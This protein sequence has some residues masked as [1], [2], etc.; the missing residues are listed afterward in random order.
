MACIVPANGRSTQPVQVNRY[1]EP[2]S[3]SMIPWGAQQSR[4]PRSRFPMTFGSSWSPPASGGPALRSRT[5]RWRS[6]AGGACAA[7]SDTAVFG[8]ASCEHPVAG[9]R[10][11]RSRWRAQLGTAPRR[12]RPVAACGTPAPVCIAPRAGVAAPRGRGRCRPRPAASARSAARPLALPGPSP[13]RGRS[14]TAPRAVRE[15]VH[16]RIRRRAAASLLG[17]LAP[18]DAT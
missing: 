6:S 4:S 3:P 5:C 16:G 18:S 17:T 7:R 14:C 12:G 13:Q 15:R 8:V 1:S 2:T 11:R 10:G 9:E